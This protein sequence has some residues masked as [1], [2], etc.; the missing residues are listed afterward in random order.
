MNIIFVES[1]AQVF[2]SLTLIMEFQQYIHE[3]KAKLRIIAFIDG[4]RYTLT[5][6][7]TPHSH[8]RSPTRREALILTPI[9]S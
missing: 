7:Q 9:P 5:S 6:L 1:L 8:L 4:I 2:L 3:V